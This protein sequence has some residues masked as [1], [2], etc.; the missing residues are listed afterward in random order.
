MSA[1]TPEMQRVDERAYEPTGRPRPEH[2]A[3][4]SGE[5]GPDAPPLSEEFHRDAKRLLDRYPTKRSA[6]MSLLY[7][8]QAEQGF[9]S[10]GAMREIASML[11]LTAAQVAAV[12][13]FYTMFKRGP[14][15]R[16]L[17]SVCTQPPCYLAGAQ[18]VM[19]RL[20]RELGV[21]CGETSSDGAI[22]LE[23]VECLCI[24]DGAPVVQVNYEF[25]ERL[26][27]DGAAELVAK[28]RAGEPPPPTRG[29]VPQPW[30]ETH[31]RLAGLDGPAPS[32][33]SQ[34]Q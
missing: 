29:D 25:Y 16:W 27:E 23:S 15:G 21:R 18:R 5:R 13:T 1:S 24:C 22:T 17:V 26:T 10:R 20:E 33:A 30:R 12:A 9:V 14:A 3:P 4:P 7:L 8:A 19:E 28:L 2:I 32:R 31:R 34:A 6:L 11:E